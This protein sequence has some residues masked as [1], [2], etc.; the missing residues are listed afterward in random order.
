M[1]VYTLYPGDYRGIVGLLCCWGSRARFGVGLIKVEG[2]GVHCCANQ[3]QMWT[4]QLWK[5]ILEQ[6][7]GGRLLE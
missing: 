7:D 6:L 3:A 1:Q 5:I 2:A 4:P